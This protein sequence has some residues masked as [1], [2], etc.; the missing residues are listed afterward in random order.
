MS[1]KPKKK[2]SEQETRNEEEEDAEFLL[3]ATRAPRQGSYEHFLIQSLAQTIF[4]TDDLKRTKAVTVAALMVQESERENLVI[5]YDIVEVLNGVATAMLNYSV[6]KIGEIDLVAIPWGFTWS[7]ENFEK[8]IVPW[9]TVRPIYYPHFMR[10]HVVLGKTHYNWEYPPIIKII[11]EP[12]W[13]WF[14]DVVTCLSVEGYSMMKNAFT[15]WAIP[16]VQQFLAELTHMVDPNLYAEML[17]LYSRRG[18]QS[19]SEKVKEATEGSKSENP[20]G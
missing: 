11:E 6:R 17:G 8:F 9:L 5:D 19:L 1:K 20:L 15:A 2:D 18:K 7:E 12:L 4:M 13:S 16:K 10:T 3:G 14:F